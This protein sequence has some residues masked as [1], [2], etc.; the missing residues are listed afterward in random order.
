MRYCLMPVEDPEV[1]IV[2]EEPIKL[3]KRQTGDKEVP[4]TLYAEDVAKLVWRLEDRDKRD[5]EKVKKFSG[6]T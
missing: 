1:G 3:Q 4:K 6:F 2:P 5:M